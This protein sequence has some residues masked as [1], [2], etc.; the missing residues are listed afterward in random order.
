MICC[1]GH[2][3][4]ENSAYGLF[5]IGSYEYD[6]K[7]RFHMTRTILLKRVEG[8]ELW[9]TISEADQHFAVKTSLR[10]ARVTNTRDDAEAFLAQALSK[11]RTTRA[12]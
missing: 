2:T 12:D 5:G 11:A 7:R 9:T 6:V 1:R 3:W 8:I 10:R 4:P